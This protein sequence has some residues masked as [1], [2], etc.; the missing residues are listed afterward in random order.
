M[1]QPT[2]FL[3]INSLEPFQGHPA[4]EVWNL[5]I[6]KRLPKKEVKLKRQQRTGWAPESGVVT[7]GK[8][9]LMEMKEAERVP[10]GAN[11]GGGGAQLKRDV[12]SNRDIGLNTDPSR[13]LR[14]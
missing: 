13:F 14:D 11:L 8:R 9:T 7:T 1:L 12:G 3:G 10:T 4:S 6:N 5:F 2:P